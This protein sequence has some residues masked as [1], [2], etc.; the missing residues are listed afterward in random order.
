MSTATL[1]RADQ[2]SSPKEEAVTRFAALAGR[3][4]FE[5]A[6]ARFL[7]PTPNQAGPVGI[8]LASNRFRNG[9]FSVD[10]ELST[11][12]EK[13]TSAG[14]VFGFQSMDGPYMSAQIGGWDTAYSFS[15]F[16]P[17]Q[18][19]VRLTSAGSL[20][21]IQVNSKQEITLQVEGQHIALV[22][23]DVKVLDY[24]AGAPIDGSGVGLY[25]WGDAPIAYSDARMV[26]K[27]LTAFVIMPFSEPF[28]TLYREVINP[29]AR[30]AK[31]SVTRVDEISG[32]GIILD[33][34]QRQIAASDAIV[35]EISTQ[36]PNVFYELG[37][38]HALK[39]PAVLLVRKQESPKLP[40]DIAGYRAIFYDDTIGGK[41]L[42]EQKL[43]DHLEA[44][45]NNG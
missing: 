33:D 18:G 28:D 22:V 21:N 29:V 39:K 34:I 14:L 35:A 6:T 30:A 7:Q 32:P 17:G 41:R 38:A 10:I 25:A 5:G 45:V 19:W 20:R 36:N 37:F 40:F 12:E 9:K 4:E 26:S 43:R 44:V 8:A 23:N 27:P 11:N 2:V 24:V 16:R 1:E 31:F 13:K 3:W 42:V 15:Q